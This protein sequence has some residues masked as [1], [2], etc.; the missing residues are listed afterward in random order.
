[1]VQPDCSMVQLHVMQSKNLLDTGI[2]KLE[3]ANSKFDLTW[4]VLNQWNGHAERRLLQEWPSGSACIA[5]GF[6]GY[7]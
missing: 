6:S 2:L 1:M 3:T 5:N 4:V 7:D